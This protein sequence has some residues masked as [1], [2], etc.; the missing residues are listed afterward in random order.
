[1]S[2]AVITAAAAPPRWRTRIWRELRPIWPFLLIF[3]AFALIALLAPLIAPNN[4]NS[5]NLLARL[6]PPGTTA[7]QHLLCARHRRGRTRPA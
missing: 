7:A 6:R 3:L 2:E 1:M 5:Q 4:P